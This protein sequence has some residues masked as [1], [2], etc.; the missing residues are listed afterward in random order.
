MIA[1]GERRWSVAL[2]LALGAPV[3][4]LALGLLALRL[5]WEP[6]E[7]GL[8]CV[9][10]AGALTVLGLH[11]LP[12]PWWARGMVA[13]AY[14]PMMAAAWILGGLVLGCWIAGACL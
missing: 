4:S 9:V 14:L 10:V 6:G 8:V 3:S 11:L 2:G 12:L 5:Q 1:T 7:I 13:T